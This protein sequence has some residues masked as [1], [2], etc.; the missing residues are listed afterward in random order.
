MA[1]AAN[2]LRARGHTDTISLHTLPFLEVPSLLFL[3]YQQF[4]ISKDRTCNLTP[5]SH[6]EEKIWPPPTLI[7]P[8]TVPQTLCLYSRTR[9]ELSNQ[10]Y[11]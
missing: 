4:L 5:K 3:E 11:A 2:A 9:T 6:E 10:L 7:V 1:A 8:A